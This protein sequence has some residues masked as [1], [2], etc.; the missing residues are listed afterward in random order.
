M[1]NP[2][3]Q[4]Q[5]YESHKEER[6]QYLREYRKKIKQMKLERRDI[7]KHKLPEKMNIQVTRDYLLFLMNLG[8]M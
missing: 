4:K 6:K 1:Y 5:Y 3:Y 7:L 8:E 2:D